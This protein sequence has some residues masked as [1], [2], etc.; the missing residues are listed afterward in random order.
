MSKKK[1]DEEQK[2][3]FSPMLSLFVNTK[4]KDVGGSKSPDYERIRLSK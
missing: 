4:S 3:A 1:L 2:A